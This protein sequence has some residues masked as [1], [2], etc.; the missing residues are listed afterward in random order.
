VFSVG[1]LSLTWFVTT[2]W[3]RPRREPHE[4]EK[5]EREMET[6]PTKAA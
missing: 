2:L 5:E 1:A 3:L 4:I 6:V